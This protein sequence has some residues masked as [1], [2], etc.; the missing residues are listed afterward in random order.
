MMITLQN[1]NLQND[2][3]SQNK[4]TAPKSSEL[5]IL[6]VEQALFSMH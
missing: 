1:V 6:L 2:V 4:S 3:Y 5:F